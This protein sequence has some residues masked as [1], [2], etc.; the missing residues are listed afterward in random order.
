MEMKCLGAHAE[1]VVVQ[2]GPND[3]GCTSLNRW[4]SDKQVMTTGM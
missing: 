2:E 4:E 1:Y 3:F